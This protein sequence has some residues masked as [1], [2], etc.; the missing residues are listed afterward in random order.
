MMEEWEV[1]NFAPV[2]PRSA[3]WVKRL[4]NGLSEIKTTQKFGRF[5]TW[6]RTV[7]SLNWIFLKLISHHYFNGQL[8]KSYRMQIPYDEH[9]NLRC[10]LVDIQKESG[11]QKSDRQTL[12]WSLGCVN[13]RRPLYLAVAG[14]PRMSSILGI[15]STG[16]TRPSSS[17]SGISLKLR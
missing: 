5:S 8:N 9:L 7:N 14:I 11:V 1:Y 15:W 13:L 16:M 17:K 12:C 2:T 10:L 3:D 4:Q 6:I